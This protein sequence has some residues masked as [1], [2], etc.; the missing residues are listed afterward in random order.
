VSSITTSRDQERSTGRLQKAARGHPLS[1]F[2]LL[3]FAVTWAYEIVVF[4]LFDLEFIPWSIPGTFV[5]ATA[6]VLVTL[7]VDGKP[8]LRA[9]W[10]RVVL[11]RVQK[12]WYLF[13]LVV[14]P[15]VVV[16]GYVFMPD[17]KQNVDDGAAMIAA[18][19]LSSLIILTLMGGGQEEPGWRGFALPR[20]Q[21][22]WGAMK[23]SSVLG[24]IWGLW[25]LPL[26]VFVPDYDN[27]DPGFV[28]TATMFVVFAGCYTI[29]LSVIFTWLVNNA[30]ESILL[31]MLAHGSVNAATSFAP[32]TALPLMMAFVAIGVLAVVIA[33]AT[34][35]Q[36]G[37]SGGEA[38]KPTPPRSRSGG[39]RV[40]AAS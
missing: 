28:P 15:A 6:A 8:G 9:F 33:V 30:R 12:R 38:S 27:A 32:E 3:T 36:L 19:Y 4:G 31:A 20:M 22:R 23:A 21:E 29:A 26:F 35:G 14:L 25:H 17:P 13:A 24:V 34:H 11:W 40:S 10:R 18:T 37:Y 2:L 39:L 7:A 1:T 5:P 16:A